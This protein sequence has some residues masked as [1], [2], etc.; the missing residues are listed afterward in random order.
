MDRLLGR[1][2]ASDGPLASPRMPGPDTNWFRL[3]RHSPA[4]RHCDLH[5]NSD[6]RM[7]PV[8]CRHCLKSLPIQFNLT[9]QQERPGASQTGP[10]RPRI[11][12]CLALPPAAGARAKPPGEGVQTDAADTAPEPAVTGPRIC[13]SRITPSSPQPCGASV[14]TPPCEEPAVAATAA[15]HLGGCSCPFAYRPD[16]GPSARRR[17]Y[18]TAPN[19]APESE[20]ET[21]RDPPSLESAPGAASRVESPYPA[22]SRPALSSVDAA[23]IAP[24]Q[25]GHCRRG[26]GHDAA[27]AQEREPRGATPT[28]RLG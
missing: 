8:G 5:H 17:R 15:A 22:P 20:G 3:R 7:W 24:Q 4:S 6:H 1:P 25:E 14:A 11:P 28:M 26:P 16:R 23:R 12:V 27:S 19:S 2:L 18:R 13:I 9:G 21:E 10:A